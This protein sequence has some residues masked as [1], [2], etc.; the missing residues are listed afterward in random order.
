MLNYV[1]DLYKCYKSP[2]YL[3]YTKNIPDKG[4]IHIMAATEPIRD[5][6][7]VKIAYK[8]LPNPDKPEPKISI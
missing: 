5:K 7:T 3:R 6:K 2:P 4:A 1:L 8:L